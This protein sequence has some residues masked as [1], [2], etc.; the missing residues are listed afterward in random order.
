MLENPLAH[1]HCQEH[2]CWPAEQAKHL[3]R[4]RLQAYYLSVVLRNELRV[5][6]SPADFLQVLLTCKSVTVPA[7]GESVGMP[8]VTVRATALG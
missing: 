1:L 6:W 5:L 3:T 2:Y 8:E 7:Q 4:T